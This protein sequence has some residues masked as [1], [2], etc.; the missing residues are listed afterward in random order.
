MLTMKSRYAVIAIVEIATRNSKLPIKL[1]D[2]SEKQNIPLN[3][4]EQIFLQLKRFNLVR[5]IKGPGGG[6]NL[7]LS[8]EKISIENI[9]D[10]VEENLKMTRCFKDKKCRKNGVSCETHN[11][12]KN[13]GHHI[14]KYFANISIADVISGEVNII[15]EN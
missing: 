10:A 7:N 12:W 8:S 5:S 13:L 6:Y 2:I 4:L 9:M 11:L 3:Y 14:R 1:A 15:N